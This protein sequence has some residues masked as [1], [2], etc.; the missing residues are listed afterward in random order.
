LPS[1]SAGDDDNT[2]NA[3]VVGAEAVPEGTEGA[4]VVDVA[5]VAKGR[6]AEGWRC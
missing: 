6:K 2:S 1:S 3:V 5:V 4:I